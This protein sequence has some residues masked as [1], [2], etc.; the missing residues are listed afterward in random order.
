M[1]PD[2]PREM[3]APGEDHATLA[4]AA[5]LECF[6]GRGPVALAGRERGGLGH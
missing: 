2:V 3:L 5:T 1:V 4:I 6:C